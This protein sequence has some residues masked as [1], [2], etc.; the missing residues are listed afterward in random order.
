M[1]DGGLEDHARTEKRLVKKMGIERTLFEPDLSE[2]EIIRRAY[3][4]RGLEIA[5][6]YNY[7]EMPQ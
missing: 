7:E 2:E 1:A 6:R 4:K 5:F 3:D